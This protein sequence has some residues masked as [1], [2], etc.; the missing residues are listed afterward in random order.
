MKRIIA[1]ILSALM[2]LAVLTACVNENGGDTTVTTGGGAQTTAEPVVT[3]NLD[4]NG[5]LKDDLPELDFGGAPFSVLTWKEPI[6]PEFI[7]E[8]DDTSGT[9]NES[10]YRRDLA[11]EERLGV[12]FSLTEVKGNN[13]N[14]ASYVEDVANDFAGAVSSHS[15]Y[16]SYSMGGAMLATGGYIDDLAGNDYI[17]LEKPWWPSRLSSQCTVNDCLYFVSG[18]I[19]SNMLYYMGTMFFNKT[20]IEDLKLEDPYKLVEDGEWTLDKMY[21]MTDGLYADTDKSGNRSAGDT[22]GAVALHAYADGFF[23]G[24][25]LTTLTSTGTSLAISPEWGSEKAQDVLSKLGAFFATGAGYYE[26]KSHTNDRRIFE[27]GRS[28]FIA[29]YAGYSEV[30][31][32]GNVDFG[33]LP[34]PMYNKDQKD[35]VGYVTAMQFSYS[36]YMIPIKAPNVEMS[37]AAI[38]CLASESYR[39]VTPQIFEVV[40]KYKFST[41]TDNAE[42]FDLIRNGVDFDLGRIFAKSIGTKSYNLFRNAIKNNTGSSWVVDFGA[43]KTAI[44]GMITAIVDGIFG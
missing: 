5:Y 2:L 36:M 37:S 39:Q 35:T 10:I 3:E 29:D 41:G 9:I 22:Y 17:D 14:L 18:D 4:A 8:G 30:L 43:E 11:A 42:M 25:G 19:S 34:F 28:L 32:S 21:E 40:Y 16:V 33:V 31:S 44:E 23:Y 27:E 38:E 6:L 24:A 20:L 1:I 12:K 26:T 15:L 13:A 7:G